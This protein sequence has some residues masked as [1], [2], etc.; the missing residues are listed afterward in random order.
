MAIAGVIGL[1]A[2]AVLDPE[3]SV[4]AVG[5]ITI[6]PVAVAATAAAAFTVVMGAPKAGGGTLNLGFPEAATLGLILRQ[7][8]PP[9]LIAIA[10]APVIAAREAVL[11]HGDPFAVAALATIPSIVIA[12]GVFAYVRTR[13]TVVF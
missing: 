8:F 2:A 4:F 10:I 9:L 1:V 6:V 13:K 12:A 11:D 7:A 5:A 3:P